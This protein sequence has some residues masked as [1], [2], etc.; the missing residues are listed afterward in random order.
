MIFYTNIIKRFVRNNISQSV[1]SI[2]L[3]LF[4]VD[5]VKQKSR[6]GII[7]V[8]VHGS[9]T[10]ALDALLA[11]TCGFVIDNIVEHGAI[12]KNCDMFFEHKI[13]LNEEYAFI[14]VYR[15]DFDLFKISVYIE[16]YRQQGI[17]VSFVDLIFVKTV[18]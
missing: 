11:I 9:K 3:P 7:S 10:T 17:T 14:G 8:P 12:I 2:G 6:A 16:K 5:I 18:K 15:A 13:N 4:N 1:I